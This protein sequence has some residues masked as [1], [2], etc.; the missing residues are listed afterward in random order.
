MAAEELPQGSGT[1]GEADSSHPTAVVVAV[2]L[3]LVA[4]MPLAAA[5]DGAVAY[6][7]RLDS[8]AAVA[9]AVGRSWVSPSS[10]Y[11]ERIRYTRSGADTDVGIHMLRYSRCAFVVYGRGVLLRRSRAA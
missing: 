3:D 8:K 2:G 10:M 5:E 4:A 6:Y 1:A 7:D 11:S 9:N